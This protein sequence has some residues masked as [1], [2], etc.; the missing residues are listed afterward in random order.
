LQ[1]RYRAFYGAQKVVNCYLESAFVDAGLV[2]PSTERE[3]DAPTSLGQFTPYYQPQLL[4]QH[5]AHL[6]GVR[7]ATARVPTDALSVHDRMN[8]TEPRQSSSSVRPSEQDLE[9]CPAERFMPRSN[10]GNEIVDAQIFSSPSAP[11]AEV[12]KPRALS[13][14]CCAEV[15]TSQCSPPKQPAT[16]E[17]DST[18]T[19]SD[20]SAALKLCREH[21]HAKHR[22]AWAQ[23]EFDLR[24]ETRKRE[25]YWNERD[26]RRSGGTEGIPREE[27]DLR[28]VEHNSMLTRQ[29]IDA[30][31]AFKAAKI[32][33]V[34]GGCRLDDPDASSVSEDDESE[35]YPPSHEAVWKADAP[36]A[37]IEG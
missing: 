27:F 25:H 11:G 3:T 13:L 7:R 35:G 28:W 16:M 17:T 31:E 24:D 4:A 37:M 2:S 10:I 22:L 14:R 20:R 36:K 32:A 34:K 19:A 12:V 30:E 18:M 29:L 15:A 6:D 23:W 5:L 26:L 21:V 1:A 8:A 9:E 33:A